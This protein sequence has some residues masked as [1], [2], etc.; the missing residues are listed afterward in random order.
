MTKGIIISVLV[1][2][3]TAAWGTDPAVASARADNTGDQPSLCQSDEQMKS[4]FSTAEVLNEQERGYIEYDDGYRYNRQ[5]EGSLWHWIMV[6]F[7][8][9][10]LEGA[11]TVSWEGYT[12]ARDD[13]AMKA[14]A[15]D[16]TMAQ[17]NLKDGT[18]PTGIWNT[19]R[20]FTVGEKYWE[21]D[22]TTGDYACVILVEG[23]TE[24]Y[25]R[26]LHIDVVRQGY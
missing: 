13:F 15:W 7:I 6:R 22:D 2:F 19:A 5:P 26:G 10:E 23:R 21:K 14:Y 3:A 1:V 12:D 8:V 18:A 20:T 24:D 4:F 17:F 9:D 16:W 11:Y 25:L